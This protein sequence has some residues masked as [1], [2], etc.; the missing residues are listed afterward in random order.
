MAP[1][2]IRRR[3]SLRRLDD[4]RH[5]LAGEI[6]GDLVDFLVVRHRVLL[7]DLLELQDRAIQDVAEPRLKMAVEIGQHEDP[8]ILVA[9]DV[10]MP[11]QDHP[12]QGERA[13]LVG[14]EHV[15]GA[16]VLDRVQPLDDHFLPRH[17]DGAA[18][19]ADRDDHRQHLGREAHGHGQG[20][21]ESASFQSPFVSPL[22]RNTSGTI[23][24]MK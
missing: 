2:Q 17:A 20:E 16:E 24:A 12:V 3:S 18:G 19:E 1:L 6:E 4:H 21:E 10:A 9:D 22:M 13:G 5:P 14:A 8:F 11:L 7:V 23:T 15:H